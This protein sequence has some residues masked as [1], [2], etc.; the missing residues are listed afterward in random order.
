[1]ELA[2][3]GIDIAICAAPGWHRTHQAMC[4]RC[5]LCV[6]RQAWRAC[7]QCRGETAAQKSCSSC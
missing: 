3:D 6:D 5:A 1:M 7:E 4:R 2:N